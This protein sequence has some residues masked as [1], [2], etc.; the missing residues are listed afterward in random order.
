MDDFI[1]ELRT[2]FLAEA[3]DLLEKFQEC[4]LAMLDDPQEDYLNEMFRILHNI[5]G[6]AQSVDIEDLSHFA[7]KVED[8]VDVLRKAEK[9][10]YS[11]SDM[12]FFL[13]SY[14]AMV[15]GIENYRSGDRKDNF[16]FFRI[17]PVNEQ[18]A[19][20]EAK[21]DV[22]VE[23]SLED[24]VDSVVSEHNPEKQN[25]VEDV[26]STKK[27]VKKADNQFIRCA[28]HKIEDMLNY[29]GEII[30]L[31]NQVSHDEPN[32]S[33]IL[34]Y[35]NELHLSCLS[36]KAVEVKSTKAVL[37][38]AVSEASKKTGKNID[39]T[40]EG[41]H[42]EIDKL[43]LQTVT[44]PLI[45]ILRNAIDHGIEEAQER[46]KKPAAGQLRLSFNIKSDHLEI[47]VK[48][49]GKGIDG[50]II[51]SKAMEKG[52]ITSSDHLSE[53]EK[54]NLILLPGFSTKEEVSDL[55]GRGVGLDVVSQSIVD[56][57][58]HVHID[59][60]INMGS[61]F[62]IQ[63]PLS[64]TIFYG[65]ITK[66]KE[67]RIIFRTSDIV[68][69]IQVKKSKLTKLS[70]MVYHYVDEK[71][72]YEAIDLDNFLEGEAIE[73]DD[74]YCSI[75]MSEINGKVFG[76]IVDSIESREKLVEKN[77]SFEKQ[78]LGARISEQFFS[79]VSVLPNGTISPILNVEGIYKKVA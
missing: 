21:R 27:P 47:V 43:I 22:E 67:R 31:V 48:D 38:R 12:E 15:T 4:S 68:K 3:M 37:T 29:L 60:K 1:E 51:A 16:N 71:V 30:T 40:I 24:I 73:Q 17:F 72:Q 41:E 33:S 56:L 10:S 70:K 52:L 25:V 57:R 63:V 58:G 18:K 61:T 64:I 6:T 44:E 74:S 54:I 7:H 46:G 77:T 62:T 78:Q 59:S 49:D 55:S 5:K 19:K 39:F 76:F 42:L 8:R 36:I 50:D 13:A 14:D 20:E 66:I 45:H 79:G 75:I 26:P 34:K 69:L 11:D 65:L 53:K 2:E 9:L 28:T 23:A 32:K 35:I